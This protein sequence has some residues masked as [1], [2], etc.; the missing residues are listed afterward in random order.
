MIFYPERL[1]SNLKYL[2][3]KFHN[4]CD[5]YFVVKSNC[6][7]IGYHNVLPILAK[8]RINKL[9]CFYAE[10]IEIISSYF[11]YEI[12]IVVFEGYKKDKKNLFNNNYAVPAII[13]NEQLNNWNNDYPNKKCWLHIDTGLGRSGISYNQM[14]NLIGINIEYI[15]THLSETSGDYITYQY[16][17][18][19]NITTNLPYKR[20]FL[21]S[22][23]FDDHSDKYLDAIRIGHALYF[24]INNTDELIDVIDICGK[25]AQI[26]YFSA[27]S[28]IGYRKKYCMETDGLI[29]I[30]DI[31][32]NN[33][34]PISAM[35]I[36]YLLVNNKQY[37]I[38]GSLSMNQTAI[39]VDNTVQVGDIAYFCNASY[40]IKQHA[41]ALGMSIA[42]IIK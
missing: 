4:I 42:S 13:S 33:N 29:A 9:C 40:P 34:I 1:T 8:Y 28:Y 12:N 24:N 23:N 37:L 16:N 41:T 18:F 5:I 26:K 39:L 2:L 3:N 7:N 14:P 21:K 15:M 30:V 25:I 22:C 20:S 17:Q 11:D 10:E 36:C 38:V 31:G 27:G 32:Y 35:N 19:I 6:Y